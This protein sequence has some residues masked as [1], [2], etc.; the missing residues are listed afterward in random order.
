MLV[1][2]KTKTNAKGKPIKAK[3]PISIFAKGSTKRKLAA[4]SKKTG[5]PQ[6]TLFARLVAALP[7]P[8][9]VSKDTK[10]CVKV[11]IGLDKAA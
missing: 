11:Y 4:Y 2:K 5:V 3:R 8:K 1:T 9:T 7:S 6:S 10:R